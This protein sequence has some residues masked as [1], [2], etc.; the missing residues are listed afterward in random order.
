MIVENQFD[1]GL[2]RSI[3]SSLLPISFQIKGASIKRPHGSE[4]L[5]RRQANSHG[6]GLD[7]NFYRQEWATAQTPIDPAISGVGIT[8]LL[9]ARGTSLLSCAASGVSLAIK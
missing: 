6:F 1:V 7:G 2:N 3:I 5:W 4:P 8:T 9:Y